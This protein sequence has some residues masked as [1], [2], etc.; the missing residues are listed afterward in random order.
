[1]S[2][3]G[4]DGLLRETF[5]TRWGLGVLAMLFAPGS[6][7]SGFLGTL[8]LLPL[9]MAAMLTAGPSRR[10][11]WS[12][13]AAAAVLALGWYFHFEAPWHDNLRCRN[14]KIFVAYYAHCLA[15]PG[16]AYVA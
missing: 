15:W 5:S 4:M 9:F 6:V 10:I 11:C 16:A 12:L 3:L 7:G 1:F 13:V 8:V 2:L 14:V